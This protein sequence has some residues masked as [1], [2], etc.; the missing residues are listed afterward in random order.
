[1]NSYSQ[2][3]GEIPYHPTMPCTASYPQ[4]GAVV[5]HLWSAMEPTDQGSFVFPCLFP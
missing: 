5:S 2:L 4:G 3:E 1:M